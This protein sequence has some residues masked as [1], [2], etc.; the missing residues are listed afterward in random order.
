[1]YYCY[2]YNNPTATASVNVPLFPHS[3][4]HIILQTIVGQQCNDEWSVII[5]TVNLNAIFQRSTA[6]CDTPLSEQ[7]KQYTSVT[8]EYKNLS[9]HMHLEI[10]ILY[11]QTTVQYHLSMLGLSSLQISIHA[12]LLHKF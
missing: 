8:G 9:A 12:F 6:V 10:P 2:V 5:R 3:A 7:Y 11:V 4:L 1:M